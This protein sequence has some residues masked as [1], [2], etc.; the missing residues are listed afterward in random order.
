MPLIVISPYARPGYISHVN[1]DFGS[2]LDFMEESLNLP[3]LGYADNLSDCFNFQQKPPIFLTISAP[4]D[5]SFFMHEQIVDT[6]PD[7]D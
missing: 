1:H 7:N 3:P 6:D 2:I 5:A 4:L